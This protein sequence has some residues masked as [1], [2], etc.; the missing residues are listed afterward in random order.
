MADHPR[1]KAAMNCLTCHYYRPDDTTPGVG[2]C[3][4]YAPSGSGNTAATVA[5]AT[6]FAPIA[7]PDTIWCGDWKKWEGAAREVA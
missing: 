1:A 5:V 7:D 2:N 6:E 4:R 3:I